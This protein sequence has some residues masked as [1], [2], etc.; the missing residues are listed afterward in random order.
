[1]QAAIARA[2]PRMPR[3]MPQAPSYR[4][5][6]PADQSILLLSLSSNT[7]PL[8]VVNEYAETRLA[9]MI[10]QTRGVAQVNVFGSQKYA[11]RVQADPQKLSTLGIGLD[12]VSNAIKGANVN[13]PTGALYGP[14]T[15]FAIEANGQL[16]NAKPYED[17]VVAYRNGAAVRV[18]DVGR[19]LDSVENDKTAAW[20]GDKNGMPRAVVLG[21]QKQPGANTVEV[22]K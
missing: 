21:I 15:A 11:V 13:L 5:V 12:D 9:Q 1:M 8:Y 20:R 17:I 7:L 2:I 6:N 22:V 10:S 19:A 18:K 4:K 16:E 14:R 3:D